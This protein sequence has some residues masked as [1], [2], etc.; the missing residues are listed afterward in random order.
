MVKVYDRFKLQNGEHV[1]LREAQ[2]EDLH[3][4]VA[5]Y[6]DLVEGKQNGSDSELHVGFDRKLDLDEEGQYLDHTLAAVRNGDMINIVAETKGKIV[7]NGVITRGKYSDTR[8]HGD[9]GLTVS[10]TLRG[11]G[12]GRA[13]I[14]RLL[15]ECRGA[16]IKTVE[17]E[18]L[19]TNQAARA[20]YQKAG[21]HETGR[22][23]GKAFRNGKYLD[24]MIM[25]TEFLR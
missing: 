22:I 2:I 13:I 4:L 18:F 12:I 8:H 20:A 19:A 1:I 5:F 3:N 16:G 25:S 17:V 9:L 15:T 6:N 14:D 23:P 10:K 11:M 24:A 21:F 7:A